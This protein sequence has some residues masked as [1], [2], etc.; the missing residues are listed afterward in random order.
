MGNA[1]SA[2]QDPPSPTMTIRIYTVDRHGRITSD[3]GTVGVRPAAVLPV[4]D[5]WSPCACPKCRVETGGEPADPI[6]RNDAIAPP[7]LTTM[8]ETVGILLDPKGAPAGPTPS[9]AELEI[10]T[11]TLRGHLDVLL[12]EVERLTAALP[13][14]SSL[15][16]CALAC[17]GEARDRLHAEPSPRYGGPAGH[18]R[19]L[20]RVLN[21]LCD[22]HEQLAY[23]QR[24]DEPGDDSR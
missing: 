8:R 14:N 15:R 11:A 5:V 2:A 1:V 21:A 12:P 4:R 3:R 13:E 9:G 23:G 20:A 19:R 16:Y 6:D 22:H 10:L 24:H 18:A 17:L 7:D